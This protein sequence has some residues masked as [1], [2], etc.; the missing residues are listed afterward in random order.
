MLMQSCIGSLAM[1]K[2]ARSFALLLL[3]LLAGLPMTSPWAAY[4]ALITGHLL[5]LDKNPGARPIG[6]GDTWRRVLA[7]SILQVAGPV[8]T[9]ACGVD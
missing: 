8:A 1:V 4:Q 5:A 2:P 7:K 3:A 9:E 6:I